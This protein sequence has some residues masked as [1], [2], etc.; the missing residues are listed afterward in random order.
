M[1]SSGTA[2]RR[3]VRAHFVLVLSLKPEP[4]PLWE[5]PQAGG[6]E[7][8]DDRQTSVSTIVSLVHCL[9]TSVYSYTSFGITETSIKEGYIILPHEGGKVTVNGLLSTLGDLEDI[10]LKNGPGSYAARRGMSFSLTTETMKVIMNQMYSRR[11]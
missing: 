8:S 9:L 7:R 6:G 3:G 2:P 4:T 5:L 10:Y 11:H 1:L